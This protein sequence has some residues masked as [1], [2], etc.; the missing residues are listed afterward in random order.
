MQN[1]QFTDLTPLI[2]RS[3]GLLLYLLERLSSPGR[4]T[5]LAAKDNH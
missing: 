5:E 4:G 3:K 2:A 1:G